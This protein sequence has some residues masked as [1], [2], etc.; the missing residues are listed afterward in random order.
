[1]SEYG[2]HKIYHLICFK[3]VTPQQ[4]KPVY[5]PEDYQQVFGRWADEKCNTSRGKGLLFFTDI[6][7]A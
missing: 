5:T 6:P 3:K 2:R 1:M 4:A 7:T